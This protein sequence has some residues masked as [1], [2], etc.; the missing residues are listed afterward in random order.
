[1]Q[2]Q[3][4]FLGDRTLGSFPNTGKGPHMEMFIKGG[5]FGA[6]FRWLACKS[7]GKEMG[8]LTTLMLQLHQIRTLTSLRVSLQEQPQ[9]THCSIQRPA[10]NVFPN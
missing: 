2:Q 6:L 7:L 5:D 9:T 1:M 4:V 3:P 10:E 8:I